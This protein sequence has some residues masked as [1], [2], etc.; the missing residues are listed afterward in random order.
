V[1]IADTDKFILFEYENRIICRRE[2]YNVANLTKKN[3]KHLVAWGTIFP[4]KIKN[5]TQQIM[6]YSVIRISLVVLKL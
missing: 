3:E 5:I 6:L 4:Q 2:S 1:I